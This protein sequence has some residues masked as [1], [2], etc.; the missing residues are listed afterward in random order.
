MQPFDLSPYDDG[1]FPT[2]FETRTL[3]SGPFDPASGRLYVTVQWADTLQGTYSNSPVVV[4]Y[5]LKTDL[6]RFATAFGGTD[7]LAC[8]GDQNRDRDVDG[9][10]LWR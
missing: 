3:G 8:P 9:V 5:G 6:K 4:V 10:D 1:E 7:C 2:S